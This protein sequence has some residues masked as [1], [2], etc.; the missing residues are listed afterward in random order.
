MLK[1]VIRALTSLECIETP[2]LVFFILLFWDD[3]HWNSASIRGHGNTSIR[4]CNPSRHMHFV[5]THRQSDY[6]AANLSPARW[7]VEFVLI[8]NVVGWETYLHQSKIHGILAPA[9]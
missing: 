2:F 8:L 3:T 5:P 9:I 4:I 1:A 6:M 7:P